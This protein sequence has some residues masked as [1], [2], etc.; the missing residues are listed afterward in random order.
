[1]DRRDRAREMGLGFTFDE[2]RMVGTII[3]EG[4]EGFGV[5][6]DIPVRFE[7]CQTCDGKGSHVNPSVDY[8]GISREDFDE[9]PDFRHD[10]FSGVY[11]VGCYGC[12]GR[13][14]TPQLAPVTPEHE[15]LVATWLEE[16]MLDAMEMAAQQRY[17][18]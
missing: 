9:D 5:E 15:A 2:K 3:C 6:V 17:G 8:N 13:R 10:Y 11:D 12:G 7:V 14:V 18:Y 16:R 1:M 4:S